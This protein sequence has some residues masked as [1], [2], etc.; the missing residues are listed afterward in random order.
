M[1]GE[2]KVKGAI[3][4]KFVKRKRKI[5]QLKPVVKSKKQIKQKNN[6]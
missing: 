6:I 1:E 2:G 5:K 4:I 3:G